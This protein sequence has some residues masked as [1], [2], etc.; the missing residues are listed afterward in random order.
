M[1]TH[2]VPYDPTVSRISLVSPERS[3]QIEGILVRMAQ[4]GQLRGKVSEEQLIE[5][6]EQVSSALILS[7]RAPLNP[8]R[9]LVSSRLLLGSASCVDRGDAKQDEHEEDDDK[10]MWVGVVGAILTLTVG[11]CPLVST[12]AGH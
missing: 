5:L 12:E 6:L 4:S 11:L 8:P 10:G 3:R 1:H 7:I 2:R 9:A